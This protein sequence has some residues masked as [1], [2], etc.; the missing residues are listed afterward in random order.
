MNDQEKQE[1]IMERVQYFKNCAVKD[2]EV[3]IDGE[4]GR[5]KQ[6]ILVRDKGRE[7]AISAEKAGDLHLKIQKPDKNLHALTF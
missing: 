2:F 6:V 7:Y 1:F 5:L 4:Y 3:E